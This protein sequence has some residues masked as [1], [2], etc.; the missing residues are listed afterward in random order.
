[1][2]QLI[3]AFFHQKHHEVKRPIQYLF[4]YFTIECKKC[5]CK[6]YMEAK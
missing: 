1:M 2:K 3:C 5:G 4:E 6:Y